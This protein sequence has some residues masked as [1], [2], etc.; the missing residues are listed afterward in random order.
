[1]DGYQEKVPLSL[2]A[3][4]SAVCDSP[5]LLG[6]SGISKK[7]KV[8]PHL[9]EAPDRKTPHVKMTSRIIF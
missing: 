3:Q 6:I 8:E 9:S 4:Q 1:M 2:V 5:M 7:K